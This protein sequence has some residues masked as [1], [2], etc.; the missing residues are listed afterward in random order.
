M[1]DRKSRSSSKSK[2]TVI[3]IG[4]ATLMLGDCLEIM[5][6]LSRVDAVVTDPPYGVDFAEWDSMRPTDIWFEKIRELA[7][8]VAVHAAQGEIWGWPKPDWIMAWFMPGSINRTRAGK[9]RHW[10]P[11]LIYGEERAPV[12]AK[13]FPPIGADRNGHPC[14][15]PDAIVRWLVNELCPRGGTVLDTFMGSGT[16]GVAALQL[17]RKFIGIE[18]E[19]KYFDIACRRIEREW[20]SPK[21][22]LPFIRPSKQKRAKLT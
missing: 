22:E 6:T 19:P 18:I 9:F 20:K 1:S 15:K 11:V 10:E 7:P 5:P 21:L 13:V 16:T 17:G 3:K 2:P 14:P 8:T 12:D 4:D